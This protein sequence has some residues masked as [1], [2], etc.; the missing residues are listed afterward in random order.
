[1]CALELSLNKFHSKQA[2]PNCAVKYLAL[3]YIH[4]THGTL[5]APHRQALKLKL[6]EIDIKHL[7]LLIS[8]N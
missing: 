3:N 1:M 2:L 5:T 4:R 8:I 7:N 6:I